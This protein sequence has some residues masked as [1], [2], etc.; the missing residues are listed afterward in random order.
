MAAPKRIIYQDIDLRFRPHPV[1]GDIPVLRNEAAVK[2]VVRNAVLTNHNERF[3]DHLFGGNIRANL[4]ENVSPISMTIAREDMRRS[5]SPM[6]KEAELIDVILT[7]P[8]KMDRNT[9]QAKMIFSV[10]R[11]QTLVQVDVFLG[12]VR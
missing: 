7:A 11:L 10:R 3:M 5:V 2:Q 1:T 4:F 8:E 9:I 6:I 12:R